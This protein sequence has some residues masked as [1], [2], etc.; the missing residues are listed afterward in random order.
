MHTGDI[1]KRLRREAGWT[2]EKLATLSGV[3]HPSICALELGYRTELKLTTAA[4]LARALGVTVDD[5]VAPHA[6]RRKSA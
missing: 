6:R 4:R 5:L 1:I 2:Q 3:S